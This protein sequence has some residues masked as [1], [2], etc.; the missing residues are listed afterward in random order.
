MIIEINNKNYQ[1]IINYKNIKNM[2]LRIKDDLN[3]YITAPKTI[4]KNEIISF[5]NNNKKSIIKMINNKENIVN[6]NKDK[7]L[8]L[9]KKYDICYTNNK[10][11]VF[12][13][14][15]I[16]IPKNLNIDNFYKKNS[17]EIF[18]KAFLNCTNNFKQ[19]NY[20]PTLRIRKMKTKWGV[21]NTTKKIIT[22]NTELIKLDEKYLNYVIYHELSHL[23]HPNHSKQ[24]WSLVEN[25]VPQYKTYKKEMK[26]ILWGKNE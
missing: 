1:V 18:T 17:K 6:E 8:Y 22:L 11:I 4:T 10:E 15:K 16:F 26:N 13:I 21:C 5:I 23:I 9:G 19:I 3:I 14:N 20:V 12:G 25:Y 24:F 7:F 2:Y